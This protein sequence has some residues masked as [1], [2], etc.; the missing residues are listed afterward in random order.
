MNPRSL[1][2]FLVAIALS[3]APFSTSV[4]AEGEDIVAF[5][6]SVMRLLGGHV[7]AIMDVVR[8][9]V[10]Y[11]D[12]LVAH[13]VSIDQLST[14][15]DD[16]F[17]E[18]TG[19]NDLATN[20]LQGIWAD[21]AGFEEAARVLQR[22]AAELTAAALSGDQVAVAASFN[23]LRRNGCDACHTSFRLRPSQ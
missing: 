8:G 20:A 11:T 13:A 12:H 9:N 5:R 6:Q 10:D 17:P 19:P 2:G 21:G 22:E 16:L 23:S 1:S 15:L 3:A 7:D 4:A 18:T 14:K